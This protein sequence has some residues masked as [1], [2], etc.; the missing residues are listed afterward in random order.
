MIII[1]DFFQLRQSIVLEGES[2]L[3]VANV[4]DSRAVIILRNMGETWGETVKLYR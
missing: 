3:Y 4:G 1:C 2:W